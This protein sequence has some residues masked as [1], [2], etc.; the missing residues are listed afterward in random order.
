MLMS[1]VVD[2]SA[3]NKEYFEKSDKSYKFQ[4]EDLLR[5][6]D[7]NGILLF[8]SKAYCEKLLSNGLNL[9]QILLDSNYRVYLQTY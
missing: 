5:G 9:F 7:E 1:A 6:I 3:F 2:P 8:D 4:A